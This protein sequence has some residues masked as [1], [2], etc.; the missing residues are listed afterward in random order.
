[1]SETFSPIWGHNI[2]RAARS[3][4]SHPCL[5]LW[6]NPSARGRRELWRAHSVG[7]AV[8]FGAGGSSSRFA[9]RR[10]VR[11]AARF[12]EPRFSSSAPPPRRSGLVCAQLPVQPSTAV[13]QRL[14]GSLR[15]ADAIR[16]RRSRAPSATRQRCLSPRP[17]PKPVGPYLL[18]TRCDWAHLRARAAQPRPRGDPATAKR[19]RQ[20]S[21][22]GTA[23]TGPSRRCRRPHMR[24]E[25]STRC[26]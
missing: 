13:V 6:P 17:P 3:A 24:C 20:G 25:H 1:M 26:C 5:I 7:R 9:V 2:R 12:R 21:W 18:P 4:C 15:I 11:R 16:L 10:C 19:P 14:R 8:E 23:T 22:C